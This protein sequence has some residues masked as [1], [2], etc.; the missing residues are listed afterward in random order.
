VFGLHLLATKSQILVDRS[1]VGTF[2][3]ISCDSWR[4]MTWALWASFGLAKNTPYRFA[5]QCT[6]CGCSL[7]QLLHKKKYELF[8]KHLS[9]IICY[10][11]VKRST[12]TVVDVKLKPVKHAKYLVGKASNRQSVQIDSKFDCGVGYNVKQTIIPKI[13]GKK[14]NFVSRSDPR[15][16]PLTESFGKQDCNMYL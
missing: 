10:L 4:V 5:D 11:S 15:R 13:K 1:F 14:I 8:N 7:L 2:P 3:S 9:L 12:R 6:T 16:K